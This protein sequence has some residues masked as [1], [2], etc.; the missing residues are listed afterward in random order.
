MQTIGYYCD[1]CRVKYVQHVCKG[2]TLPCGHILGNAIRVYAKRYG[3]G[4]ERV[5]I[6]NN[7]GFIRKA[8]QCE[9]LAYAPGGF[10]FWE[11]EIQLDGGP[12]MLVARWL[13]GLPQAFVRAFEYRWESH[14]TAPDWASLLNEQPK[15]MPAERN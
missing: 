11:N 2:S 8:E 13:R 7:R 4:G 6:G 3:R 5:Q 14:K 15:S 1:E 9:K 10:Y 12:T